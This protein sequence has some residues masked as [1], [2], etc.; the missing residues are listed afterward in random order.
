MAGT[1]AQICGV[2]HEFLIFAC[3][4]SLRWITYDADVQLKCADDNDNIG[5][6][7]QVFSGIRERDVENIG[8]HGTCCCDEKT[9]REQADNNNLLLPR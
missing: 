9:T 5:V 6:P 1:E 3:S 7:C 2:D 4:D 8:P